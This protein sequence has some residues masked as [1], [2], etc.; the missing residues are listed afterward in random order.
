MKGSASS[1]G[2]TPNSLK[3]LEKR[4]LQKNEEGL[5]IETPEELFRRVAKTV[6]AADLMYGKSEAEEC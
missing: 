5:P 1:I 6:A 2:L 4:Y 3:V